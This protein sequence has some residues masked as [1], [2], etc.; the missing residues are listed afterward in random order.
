MSPVTVGLLLSIAL[1]GAPAPKAERGVPKDLIDLLPED[2]AAAVVMDVTRI[3][4]SEFG[5]AF[6]KGFS[7]AQGDDEPIRVADIVREVE[8]ALIAQF[9]IEEYS[10]DFCFILRLREG[11]KL[12]ESL[13]AQ[14]KKGG[15][16]AT[17]EKIGKRTVYP[18]GSPGA[19]FTQLDDRTLMVVLAIGKAKQVEETRAAAYGERDK[20][21]PNQ[22]LRKMLAEEPAD[23]PAIRLYGSHPTKLGHSAGLILAPYGVEFEQLTS[24]GEKFVSYRGAIRLDGAAQ[25]ELRFT[26]K[27]AESAK[28]LLTRYEAGRADDDAVREWRSA[29]KAV[30]EGDEVIVTGKATRGLI[31]RLTTNQ[32]K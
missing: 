10:G 4:K 15:R 25:V 1:P 31:D 18:I 3:A 28:D 6:W 29:C 24:I 26:L 32:R 16:D 20:P 7:A 19:S 17:P 9:L 27:D 23:V 22:T 8:F 11:S 5:A 14:A 30:R 12:P 21:G 2:T 13:M